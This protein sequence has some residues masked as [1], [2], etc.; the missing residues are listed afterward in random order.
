MPNRNPS[1]QNQTNPQAAPAAAATGAGHQAAEQAYLNHGVE[2]L[3][4]M[5]NP[6]DS[7]L[8]AETPSG[9]E[10]R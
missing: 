5:D 6:D 9:A 3:V 7:Q 2:S 4:S 10:P 1:R 8:E